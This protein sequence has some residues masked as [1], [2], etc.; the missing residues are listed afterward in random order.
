MSI[1]SGGF[2]TCTL[3]TDG[4]IVCWGQNTYGQLGIGNTTNV[5]TSPSQMGN[6]LQPVN[7]GAGP[8]LAS[9]LS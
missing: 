9:F 4:R 7:L 6:N 8:N 2:H 5:G 1:A 3:R